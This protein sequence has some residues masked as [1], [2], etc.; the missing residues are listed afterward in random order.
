MIGAII[1]DIA[2]SRFEWHNIKTKEFELLMRDCF[3]TDDTVMS[4]AICEALMSCKN[5]HSDLSEKAVESIIDFG[6]KGFPGVLVET[7]AIF[8]NNQGR[9]MKT[10]LFSFTHGIRLE[11]M[12]DYIFDK[13]LPYWIIY[14]DEA[15]D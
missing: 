10:N 14:R 5:N 2:G 7:L 15:F 13:K 4:L 12:Q 9:P 3:F 6:E 1:G 8:I 11:Q